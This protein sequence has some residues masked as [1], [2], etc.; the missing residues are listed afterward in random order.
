MKI[1]DVKK[2]TRAIAN[3]AVA[4]QQV[5]VAAVKKPVKTKIFVDVDQPTRTMAAPVTVQQQYFQIHSDEL[6]DTD[7]AEEAAPLSAPLPEP[8]VSPT[9]PPQGT[10]HLSFTFHF[11]FVSGL[12]F[13]IITHF[14]LI[15]FKIYLV[16][17]ISS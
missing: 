5:T 1:E 11:S 10:F 3:K 9:V 7:N 13:N 6:S 16:F 12:H 15:Y 8:T 4:S 2:P 14:Y 17:P